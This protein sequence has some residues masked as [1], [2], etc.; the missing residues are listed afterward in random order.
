MTTLAE[1]LAAHRLDQWDAR[2]WW[3]TSECGAYYGN[4]EGSHVAH[5]VEAVRAAGLI[6][7]ELPGSA[8]AD[9]AEAVDQ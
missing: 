1:V 9:A 5:V 4:T 7:V 8:A 3:C 6:V 2:A